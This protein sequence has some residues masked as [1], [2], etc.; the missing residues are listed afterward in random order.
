MGK[1]F[2]G[3]QWDFSLQEREWPLGKVSKGLVGSRL[4]SSLDTSM[5]NCC[6]L[7]EDAALEN[8]HSSL[9]SILIDCTWGPHLSKTLPVRQYIF[10]TFRVVV[11]YFCFYCTVCLHG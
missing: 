6:S 2:F 3:P 7:K 9:G 11:Y 1:M 10:W 4:S 5:V 8:L